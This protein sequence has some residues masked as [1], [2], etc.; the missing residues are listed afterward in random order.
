MRPHWRVRMP[1]ITAWVHRKT[2]FRFTAMVRS[3]S[4]S[5]S[6]STGG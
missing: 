6:S 2:D 4:S 5:V 1:G 3:K